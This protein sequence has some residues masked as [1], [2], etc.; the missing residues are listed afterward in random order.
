LFKKNSAAHDIRRVLQD[1]RIPGHQDRSHASKDLPEWKVPGHDG[2][3]RAERLILNAGAV[4]LEFFIHEEGLAV[5]GIKVAVAG[6]LLDFRKT[7][8]DRLA[9]LQR[10]GLCNLV[11]FFSK[12]SCYCPKIFR[13]LGV[14]RRLPF[15]LSDSDVGKNRLDFAVRVTCIGGDFLSSRWIDNDE[16]RRGLFLCD[17]H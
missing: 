13:S 1:H 10:H 2:K 6:A 16:G 4:K 3:D 17:S 11:G 5:F 15:F 9:H 14:R 12:L 8:R 7:L